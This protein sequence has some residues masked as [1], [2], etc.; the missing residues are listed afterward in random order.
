ME[1]IS[2]AI[3]LDFVATFKPTNAKFKK[4]LDESIKAKPSF[5]AFDLDFKFEGLGKLGCGCQVNKG[6]VS[7]GQYSFSAKD[8][9]VYEIKAHCGINDD[10]MF[11]DEKVHAAFAKSVGANALSV[12]ISSV[13]NNGESRQTYWSM[14]CD[15]YINL[16]NKQIL[17]KAV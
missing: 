7:K 16:D 11:R 2:Y 15:P 8:G 12:S 14:E 1:V 9:D 5:M 6:N 3:S 13:C 4:L 10:L 17:F